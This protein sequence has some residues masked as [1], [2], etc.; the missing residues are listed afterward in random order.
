LP[1]NQQRIQQRLALG[2]LLFGS[3]G[4]RHGRKK[5]FVITITLMG[6]ATFSI[7]LLPT[8]DTAGMWAPV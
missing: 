1:T 5:A 8:K 3:F 6:F 4:D 2:A 7:G